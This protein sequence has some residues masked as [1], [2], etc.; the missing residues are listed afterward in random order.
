ML[1]A[2]KDSALAPKSNSLK[3]VMDSY[4]DS[5][6]AILNDVKEIPAI[7]IVNGRA[8]HSMAMGVLPAWWRPLVVRTPWFRKGAEAVEAFSGIVIMTVAKRLAAPSHRN[9]FLSLLLAG[10]DVHVSCSFILLIG[11]TDCGVHRAN[12]WGARSSQR[13]L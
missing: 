12:L 11:R 2:A 7:A 3:Q 8:Q 6:S 13:K 10:K 9:D 5:S 4:G 1:L